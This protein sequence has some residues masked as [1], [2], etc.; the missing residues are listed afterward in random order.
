M[1][2]CFPL[3]AM[4]EFFFWDDRP[5]YPCSCFVR[6]R[7]AGCLDRAAF[8]RAIQTLL[9]R[10]PMFTAKVENDPRGRLRWSLVENPSPRIVWETA[11]IGDSL[12]PATRLD[13][14]REI[15]IRFHVRTS[16]SESDLTIQIHHACCDGAGVSL[17]IR[18]FLVIYA[19][20]CGEVPRRTRLTPLDPEK[21]AG[22][23]RFGLTFRKFLKMVPRQM[24]GLLGARQ[25]LMRKPVPIIPHQVCPNDS[26]LPENYPTTM[27]YTLTVEET[28]ALRKT[29]VR[30]R[31]TPNDLLARDLFLAIGQWQS[32]HDIP[33]NGEWIRMMVPVNLRTT[34]DRLLPATDVVSSVF[35]DRRAAD[36]A[37]ADQLLHGIHEEMDLIKR[38]DL[39][40][41][42]VFSLA[43]CRRLFGSL[44]K[45][46]QVD[47]CSVSCV[48]SNLGT[49]FAHTP[50]PQ[51]ERQYVAGN[52]T[53]TGTDF[54]APIHPYSCATFTIGLYAHKQTITL[55]YDPRPLSESQAADLLGTYIRRI[56]TSIAVCRTT[57]AVQSECPE[58]LCVDSDA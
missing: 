32:R 58:S 48:F 27:T 16:G 37:D 34:D 46:V 45:K 18:E 13:L 51:D 9:T 35:L 41:T 24:V 36:F 15:G 56:Q 39:G 7:F 20:A 31:V 26:P 8:D 19:M 47:Q 52:V 21:L 5:A 49:P 23:G 44:K 1:K 43:V 4:E 11:S 2:K 55:H 57:A 12:P 50:L 3:T 53:M 6:L 54:V 25:F 10:H 28:A 30:H 33:Q 14:R 17:F 22:R 38:N 29:A 42:F 40:F